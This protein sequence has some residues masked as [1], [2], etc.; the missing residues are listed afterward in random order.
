[1]KVGEGTLIILL[2][3]I[4]LGANIVAPTKSELESMYAAAAHEVNAGRYREALKQ[5]DA[6]DARQ[7]EMAA[8][9]NLRGVALLRL[10][11]FGPA[12][13]ALRKAREYDPELW[14]ARFNLAEVPFLEKRW[15]EARQ[16]FEA[17]AVGK[18]EQAQGTTGE[19]IQFKILLTYLLEGKEKKA[20]AIREQFTASSMSPA[21]YYAKAAFAFRQK[22]EGEARVAIKA[23]E[24]AYPKLLNQLFAESFYEIGWLQ[25]EDGAPPVALEVTSLGDRAAQAQADFGKADRAWRQGEYDGALRLLDQVDAIAPNQ[26]VSYTLRGQ[27]FF[28]QGKNEEAAAAWRTALL[29]D[30][31]FVEARYYL[32]RLPFRERDYEGAR[33]QFEALL[34]AS[35]GG[36]EERQRQ[37]LIQYQIYLTLL[38][39]GRDGPAQ[40]ALDDFKMMDDTPAL[41][42]AQAAWAFQHGNLKQGSNWLANAANLFSPELNRAFTA[43][44]LDLGWAGQTNAPQLT[45]KTPAAVAKASPTPT[46][47]PAAVAKTSPT[48]ATPTPT[49]VAAKVTPAAATRSPSAT[50]VAKASP[51]PTAMPAA[52]AKASPTPAATLTPAKVAAKSTP[53]VATT[54]PTA[55][56]APPVKTTPAA[57]AKASP[58]PTATPTPA[59]AASNVSPA[60]ATPSPSATVVAK[61]SPTPSATPAPVVSDGE[62]TGAAPSPT[63]AT[64]AAKKVTDK[65]R[66]GETETAAKRKERSKVSPE[67]KKEIRRATR[68][69]PEPPALPATPAPPRNLGDLLRRALNTRIKDPPGAK[70]SPSPAATV[71]PGSKAPDT[72]PN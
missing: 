12:E 58:I 32:A 39:E 40:K 55:T 6:I 15:A 41:Y 17:L 66:S 51:A 44:L 27:I 28:A 38:L 49:I 13:K 72:R 56:P 52:V 36:K 67:E 61:A 26:A 54:S 8:A 18:S 60:A 10:R 19:L 21:H 45:E 22:D 42:Y 4:S 23:A 50:V 2:V 35:A 53:A 30:P 71:S 57:I 64:P 70:A 11:E 20:A 3:L 33:R 46:A 29:A 63:A 65:K 43:P 25:K 34:G 1:M 62:K 5:L 7:P 47:T 14:E 48:P 69:V 31:Q 68:V 16:R 59:I 37:Q 9:K 24:K